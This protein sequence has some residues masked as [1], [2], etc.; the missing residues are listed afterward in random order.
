MENI[1]SLLNLDI[2]IGNIQDISLGFDRYYPL[3][4]PLILIAGIAIA[5]F[6]NYKT[7]KISKRK[8][9]LLT[10]T[11]ILLIITV[12]FLLYEPYVSFTQ[13]KEQKPFIPILVDLSRSMSI[14]DIRSGTKNISRFAHATSTIEKLINSLKDNITFKLFTFAQN[15]ANPGK[16][17]EESL[18]SLKNIQQLHT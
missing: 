17:K 10:L 5:L 6:L 2:S 12:V 13:I 8:S 4:I 7:I 3:S 15:I 14:N 1:L 9:A 11:R 18:K 16:V